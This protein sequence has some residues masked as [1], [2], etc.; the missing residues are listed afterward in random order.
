L[1]VRRSRLR[2]YTMSTTTWT[3][4]EEAEAAFEAA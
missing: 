3:T 2:R 1:R 4:L